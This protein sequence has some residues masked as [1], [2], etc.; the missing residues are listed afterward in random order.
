[1]RSY[2]RLDQKVQVAI[3]SR[4]LYS[5]YDYYRAWLKATAW[6]IMFLILGGK[7]ELQLPSRIHLLSDIWTVGQTP[8]T[9]RSIY[10]IQDSFGVL[11]W[12]ICLV[13]V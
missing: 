5:T 6:L 4:Y 11:F 12:R 3:L 7:C 9:A 10:Y 13:R 1:M 8:S 2:K